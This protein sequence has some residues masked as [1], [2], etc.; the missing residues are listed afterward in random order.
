MT[1]AIGITSPPPVRLCSAPTFEPPY[2]DEVVAG[3][4]G[5]AGA[6]G[7]VGPAGKVGPLDVELPLDWG[8]GERW[9]TERPA[10]HRTSTRRG[11]AGQR[12]ASDQLSAVVRRFVDMYVEVLNI[13]RPLRH[14]R[15]VM[16]EDAF[17]TTRLALSQ[18]GNAWWPVP[19]GRA[20][21]RKAHRVVDVRS[22]RP[23]MVIG[24]RRLRCCRPVPDVAEVAAVLNRGDEVRAIGFRLEREDPR[25][26][27]TALE[28]VG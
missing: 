3:A 10:R 24:V 15:P 16:T 21:A 27:C 4:T 18:R 26:L 9:H 5:T 14:L 6:T 22:A 2:D 12:V 20:S 11:V 7:S 19:T 17:E 25:W 13:R 8:R 23:P 1:A 28:F